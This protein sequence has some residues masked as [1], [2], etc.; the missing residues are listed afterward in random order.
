MKSY[1]MGMQFLPR[2]PTIK[3]PRNTWKRRAFWKETKL[4]Q[5]KCSFQEV[6]DREEW[7]VHYCIKRLNIFKNK[8]EFYQEGLIALWEAYQRY[9]S[10]KG[11]TF[12]TFAYH[13]VRGKMLTCL[14]KSSKNDNNQ[15]TLTDELIEVTADPHIVPVLETETLSLYCEGLT[16][17]QKKWVFLHFFE[18]R[19]QKEIANM[20]Q[21]G[22]E[23]V[24]SWRRYALQKIRK[25]IERLQLIE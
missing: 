22:H 24:K 19:G 14:R 17:D 6:L 15:A 4:E 10:T 23:T 9:D 12:R 16:H 8:D 25:N 1:F 20:E 13:T 7:V 5:N 2:F 3:V 18:G 11:S 21:V